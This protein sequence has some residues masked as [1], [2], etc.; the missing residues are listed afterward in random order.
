MLMIEE[1]LWVLI[2]SQIK[3]L[4]ILVESRMEQ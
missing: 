3:Y 4:E 2:I 1:K